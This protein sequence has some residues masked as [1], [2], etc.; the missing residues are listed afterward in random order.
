MSVNKLQ[1]G[2]TRMQVTVQACEVIILTYLLRLFKMTRYDLH[3]P[4]CIDEYA[5][6]TYNTIVSY[7]FNL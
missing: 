6:V 4:S 1:L 5:T 3:Y 7:C 2:G